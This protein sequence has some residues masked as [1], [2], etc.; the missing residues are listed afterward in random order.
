MEVE[1]RWRWSRGEP[2][3]RRFAHR[4]GLEAQHAQVGGH[5][6]ADGYLD[7]VARHKVRRR[8]VRHELAVAVDLCLAALQ[9]RVRNALEWPR[10]LGRSAR[11]SEDAGESE[12]RGGG[13]GEGVA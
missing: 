12:W 4:R 8:Q 7:D 5:L 1:P 3:R 10:W 2:R 9:R 13:D 11:E 6:V